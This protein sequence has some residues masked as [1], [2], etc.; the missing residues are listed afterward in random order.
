[1]SQITLGQLLGNNDVESFEE[2]DLT[3]V[4]KVLKSLAIED[5]I[6]IAHAE[7]LQQRSLYG[8]ELLID[9]SAKMV[10]TV[11]F[12]ESKMNSLK[13]KCALEYKST[14]DKVRVTA[15]MRKNASECDPRVE[16]LSYILAK[17][18]GAKLAIEKKLD[19]I[20]KT[21]YH[22][23]EVA[24]NHK[25]GIISGTAKAIATEKMETKKVGWG[26]KENN[27]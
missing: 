8:A 14:D 24:Q 19:L 7:Y 10:K 5:P 26:I 6:D 16:E 18:K 12:L 3:E 22:F 11:G 17:A 23:K 4:Q 15:E 13:N 9:L 21:H 2:F 1:M 25:Q 20:L 27:G